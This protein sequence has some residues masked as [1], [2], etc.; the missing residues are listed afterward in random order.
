MKLISCPSS[1]LTYMYLSYHMIIS[2][3]IT[4]YGLSVNYI[5]YTAHT[6]KTSEGENTRLDLGDM[7]SVTQRGNAFAEIFSVNQTYTSDA[8]MKWRVD[9][10]RC[11]VATPV[12]ANFR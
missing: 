3:L 7:L 12:M 6:G 8:T 10:G 4:E 9:T 2:V 1:F 5:T 11:V